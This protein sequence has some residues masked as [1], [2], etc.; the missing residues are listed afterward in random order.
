MTAATPAIDVAA[1][2]SRGWTATQK[3]GVVLVVP[4]LVVFALFVVYPVLYAFWL[5][6]DPSSYQRLAADPIFIW[7][8]ASLILLY[9]LG[10][11]IIRRMIDLKV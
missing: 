8:F 10:V 1:P 7:G 11:F 2:A 3:W 6:H 5:A 4:Y 9:F